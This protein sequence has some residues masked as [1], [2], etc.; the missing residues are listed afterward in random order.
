M[1]VFFNFNNLISSQ[2][3]LWTPCKNTDI[4]PSIKVLTIYV[5]WGLIYKNDLGFK[6][7]TRKNMDIDFP[8]VC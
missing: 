2:P 3:A 6:P 4:E 7:L 1:L 5:T 8:L